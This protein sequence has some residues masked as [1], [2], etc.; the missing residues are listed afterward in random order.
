MKN[1]SVETKIKDIVVRFIGK[2]KFDGVD[3]LVGSLLYTDISNLLSTQQ[4]Q[5]RDKIKAKIAER[6]DVID[7]GCSSEVYEEAETMIYTYKD[8]LNILEN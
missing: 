8:I 1:S 2:D 3:Q 7:K 4:A 6:Q 5:M